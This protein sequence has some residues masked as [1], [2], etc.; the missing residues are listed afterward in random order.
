MDELF[1]VI[2]ENVSLEAERSNVELEEK[3]PLD[4]ISDGFENIRVVDL[5]VA[6]EELSKLKGIWENAQENRFVHVVLS[7]ADQVVEIGE[8]YNINMITRYGKRLRVYA[9]SFDIEKME[10]SLK[11]FRNL[12]KELNSY[13]YD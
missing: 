9:E 13:L 1:D 2:V 4:D 8:S 5:K 12:E 10:K 6:L 7:F 11:D 3:N